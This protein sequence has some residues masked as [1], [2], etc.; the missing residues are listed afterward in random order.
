MLI[1]LR[2][3]APYLSGLVTLDRKMQVKKRDVTV[4][5]SLLRRE[6]SI[7]HLRKWIVARLTSIIDNHQVKKQEDL[8][9]DV[10]R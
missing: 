6:N 1:C 10:A 8:I 7:F 3:P 9:M 2:I 4:N 5:F